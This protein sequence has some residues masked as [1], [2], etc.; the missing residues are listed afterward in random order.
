MGESQQVAKVTVSQKTILKI[1][2]VYDFIYDL[3]TSQ[4]FDVVEKEF[5][6]KD[7]E[8]SFEWDCYRWV[9]DYVQFKI[10]LKCKI[11]EESQ[12]KV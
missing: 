12:V 1:K 10:W 7:T 2:D 3:V 11:S 8:S 4:G 9:D 6:K 5:I